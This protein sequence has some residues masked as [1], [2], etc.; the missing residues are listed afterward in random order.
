MP[1]Q[2]LNPPGLAPTNGWAHVVTST[3]GKTVHVS[4]QVG[5]DERG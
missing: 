3:G 5:V 4:G 2:F 1:T